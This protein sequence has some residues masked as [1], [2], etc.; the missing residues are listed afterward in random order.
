M[1]KLMAF[2]SIL[3]L[4]FLILGTKKYSNEPLFWLA[5]S[6]QM[7]Q[8]LRE[9]LI[10]ILTIQILTKR[11]RNAFLRVISGSISIYIGVWTIYETI[12]NQIL[13]LDSLVFMATSITIA[14]ITLEGSLMRNYEKRAGKLILTTGS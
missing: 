14:I 6:T 5:N 9:G 2:I 3:F 11:P 10:G 4:S 1:S 13:I 8:Y 7:F 12:A